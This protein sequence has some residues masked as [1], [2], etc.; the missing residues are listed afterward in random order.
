MLERSLPRFL[1]AYRW[2]EEDGQ[3]IDQLPLVRA[4]ADFRP[5][6]FYS[7]GCFARHVLNNGACFEECPKEFSREMTQGPNR[8]QVLTRDCVSYLFKVN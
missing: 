6:L 8:F 3:L 1:F 7:L 4:A 5:P 2:I